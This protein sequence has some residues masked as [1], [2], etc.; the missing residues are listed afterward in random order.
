MLAENV[1]SHLIP[2]PEN[3]NSHF[4]W[5]QPFN[6]QKSPPD[7]RTNSRSTVK[8]TTEQPVTNKLTKPRK[9]RRFKREANI[10]Q[11]SQ[12][13][14]TPNT[15]SEI[16]ERAVHPKLKIGVTTKVPLKQQFPTTRSV[17]KL[18]L[19]T[20]QLQFLP[21]TRNAHKVPLATHLLQQFLPTT[22]NA[23]EVPLST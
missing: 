13:G 1:N 3:A 11:S 8:T 15:L 20:Q 5:K 18:P 12:R 6:K 19:S 9:I 21:T 2:T 22:R 14:F 7:C 4:Y 16:P 23:P 10:Q 17:P